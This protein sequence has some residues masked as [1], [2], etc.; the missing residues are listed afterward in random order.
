MGKVERP[1]PYPWSLTMPMYMIPQLTT[2]Q[3]HMPYP[4]PTVLGLSLGGSQKAS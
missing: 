3:E 2:L 4:Q 1:Q